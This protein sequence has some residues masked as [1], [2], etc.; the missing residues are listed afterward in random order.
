MSNYLYFGD[1][2]G[3]LRAIWSAT[4]DARSERLI[5]EKR[6]IS[7][8]QFIHGNI[9]NDVVGVV[10]GGHLAGGA[11]FT[12]GLFHVSIG[13]QFHWSWMPALPQLLEYGFGRYG[14]PL[15]AAIHKDNTRAI[16]CTEKGG[17]IRTKEDGDFVFFDLNRKEMYYNV[18]NV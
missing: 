17:G 8:V 5:A 2:I 15:V 11:I 3:I 13:K 7:E 16:R 12:N 1:K 18:G 14:S 4:M 9:D 10:I 6:K